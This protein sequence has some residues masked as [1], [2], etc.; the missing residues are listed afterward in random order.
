MGRPCVET[1]AIVALVGI[2]TVSFGLPICY[3]FVEKENEKEFSNP[4]HGQSDDGD[5]VV[6]VEL[7]DCLRGRC[8]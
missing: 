6:S 5:Q 3:G 4:I 8:E 7:S 1:C 2:V